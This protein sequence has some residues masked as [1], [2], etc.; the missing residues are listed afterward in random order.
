MD[1]KTHVHGVR[2]LF[3]GAIVNFPVT[4]TSASPHEFWTRDLT[5]V[6]SD[7]P[8]FVVTAFGDTREALMTPEERTARD[9]S[10]RPPIRSDETVDL[11][12]PIDPT[13]TD[14][15][16]VPVKHFAEATR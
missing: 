4:P 5:L 2:R 8:G 14:T 11:A 1:I 10:T 15:P 3:L 12:P 7:G 9:D 13:E 16:D 6:G